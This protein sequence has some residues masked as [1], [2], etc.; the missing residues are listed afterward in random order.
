[1][2]STVSACNN[3]SDN[4]TEIRYFGTVRLLQPKQNKVLY[5][6]M[7]PIAEVIRSAWHESKRIGVTTPLVTKHRYRRLTTRT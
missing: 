5:G 6:R 1:M 2:C 7:Q 4:I 3:P